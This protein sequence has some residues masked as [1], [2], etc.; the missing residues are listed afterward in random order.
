MK[1][2]NSGASSS[3]EP[4][5]ISKEVYE[6]VDYIWSIL[7]TE[8]GKGADKEKIRDNIDQFTPLFEIIDKP[9]LLTLSKK[10]NQI[11]LDM[12]IFLAK[13]SPIYNN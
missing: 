5:N 7:L 8:L 10:F 1:Q 13:K 9:E 4:A 2:K 12:E 11:K 3:D 6:L